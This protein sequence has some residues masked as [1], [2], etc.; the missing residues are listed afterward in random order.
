M[1]ER[2]ERER[3]RVLR[4]FHT[5]LCYALQGADPTVI[6]RKLLEKDVISEELYAELED[7]PTRVDQSTRLML[8]LR[9]AAVY[10]EEAFEAFLSVL[11]ASTLSCK[12]LSRKLRQQLSVPRGELT[13]R[14]LRR[15]LYNK[16]L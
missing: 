15:F 5:K 7:L 3:A 6:A 10:D 13:H 14:L 12:N 11:D 8:S 16:P 1:E 2:R 4:K 9:C